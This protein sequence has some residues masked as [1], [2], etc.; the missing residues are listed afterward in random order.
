LGLAWML[1]GL[2][3]AALTVTQPGLMVH[4]VLI[5]A[6]VTIVCYMINTKWTD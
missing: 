4:L 1:T 3:A 2:F 5:S 6:I